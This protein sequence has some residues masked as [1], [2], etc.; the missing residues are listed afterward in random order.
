MAGKA[1]VYCKHFERLNLLNTSLQGK[2]KYI[3]SSL[4]KVKAFKLK[5]SIWKTNVTAGNFS[6]FNQLDGYMKTCGWERKRPGM[7]SEVSSVVLSHLGVLSRHFE[8]YFPEEQ[9]ELLQKNLWILDPFNA[10]TTDQELID[11]S[12]DLNQKV[13]FQKTN[14]VDFWVSLFK[15]P[16]YKVVCEKAMRYLAQMPTTYLCEQAFSC[17]VDI[18]STKRNRISNI[19]VLMRGAVET[20]ILPRFDVLSDNIQEQVSH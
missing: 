20:D 17:L 7:E 6:D 2:K 11:L 8:T 18:K 16:E 14:Y 9:H 1:G 19:D 5:I 10:E 12:T 4:S 3:F 15:F 13:L